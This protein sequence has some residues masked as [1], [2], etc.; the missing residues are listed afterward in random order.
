VCTLDVEQDGSLMG[1]GAM[2]TR[3][4]QDDLRA[5]AADKMTKW[6]QQTRSL[7]VH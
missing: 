6:M 1:R 7:A 3:F 4:G 2:G 5:V